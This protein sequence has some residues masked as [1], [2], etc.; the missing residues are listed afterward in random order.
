MRPLDG[1]SKILFW[2]ERLSKLPDSRVISNHRNQVCNGQVFNNFKILLYRAKIIAFWCR[3][4]Y[5]RQSKYLYRYIPAP[6]SFDVTLTEVSP[7]LVIVKDFNCLPSKLKI[8]TVAC[9]VFSGSLILISVS[10]EKGSGTLS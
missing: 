7:L 3:Q 4:I 6:K 1:K 10:V 2:L 8:I 5:H 9:C